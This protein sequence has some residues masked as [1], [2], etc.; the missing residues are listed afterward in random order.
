MGTKPGWRGAVQ[1]C[2]PARPLPSIVSPPS[3]MSGLRLAGHVPPHPAPNPGG[4]CRIPR[5]RDAVPCPR[6]HSKRRQSLSA[7]RL[8]VPAGAHPARG[9]GWVGGACCPLSAPRP[10][11]QRGWCGADSPRRKWEETGPGGEG[12]RKAFLRRLLPWKPGKNKKLITTGLG[13]PRG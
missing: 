3:Q 9:S 12:T 8:S 5:S 10:G 1:S 6:S 4:K 11:A 2:F 13:Q 7:L